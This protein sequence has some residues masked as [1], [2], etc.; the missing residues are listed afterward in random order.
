MSKKRRNYT[1]EF[2]Q[3]ALELWRSSGKSAQQ[4][5]DDLGISHGLLYK[6]KGDVQRE[7]AAAFPGHG[8]VSASEA[9][10]RQLQRELAVVREERDILKKAVAIFAHPKA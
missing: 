3:E 1:R 7:G 2:K 9:E 6:W 10:V 4:V 8:Q 5:E